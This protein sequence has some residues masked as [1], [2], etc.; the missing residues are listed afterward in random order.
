MDL[1]NITRSD[2]LLDRLLDEDPRPV[3]LEPVLEPNID[4]ALEMALDRDLANPDKAFANDLRWAA[5]LAPIGEDGLDMTAWAE[6]ETDEVADFQ[7]RSLQTSVNMAESV[8]RT[9]ATF[10]AIKASIEALKAATKANAVQALL[11]SDPLL[12]GDERLV[13]LVGV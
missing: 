11:D 3:A 13:D 2:V 5:L 9:E 1:T 12:S 8:L 10:T 6:K 4:R 7:A